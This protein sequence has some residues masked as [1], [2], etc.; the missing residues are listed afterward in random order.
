MLR[1]IKQELNVLL[2]YSG[3]LLQKCVLLN[4]K[5]CSP[6]PSLIDLNLDEL[7]EGLHHY[8]FMASLDKCNGSCN[9]LDD[10][11]CRIC[12]PNKTKHVN[13]NVFNKITGTNKS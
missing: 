3:S 4:K 8:P 11:S 9:T 5:P 7:N 10:P 13:L 6:R 12:V 2:S 1:L